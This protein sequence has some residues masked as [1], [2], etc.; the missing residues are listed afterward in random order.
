[1]VRACRTGR[2]PGWERG[3]KQ[4]ICTERLEVV[5]VYIETLMAPHLKVISISGISN[6]ISF[7]QNFKRGHAW[8]ASYRRPSSRYDSGYL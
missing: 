2:L 7:F 1:M 5:S 6:L 4:N 3:G 8:P